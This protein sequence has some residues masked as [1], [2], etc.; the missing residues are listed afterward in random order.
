MNTAIQKFNFN[1]HELDVSRRDDDVFVSVRRVCE[2]LGIA[3]DAQRVK[4]RDKVW[5]RSTIIV[6][7]DAR[8]HMQDA[9]FLHLDSLPM[10]LATIDANKVKPAA[11]PVLEEFQL[12]CAKVL[13]DYFF[14]PRGQTTPPVEEP[15]P[16]TLSMLVGQL[17]DS[18][19]ELADFRNL[20]GL[21][22][23]I[24]GVTFQRIHGIVR[25]ENQVLSYKR[26]PLDRAHQYK[27]RLWSIANRVLLLPPR[28]KGHSAPVVDIRQL[29]LP[30]T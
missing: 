24:T 19:S 3:F 27:A 16:P 7:P 29:E 9:F 22:V 28:L 15:L 10:W 12:R 5:A 8:G 14:G 6:S 23:K 17:K 26:L 2:C 20:M 11:R 1:G 21:C 30:Q 25:S 18:P 13:R 4:L